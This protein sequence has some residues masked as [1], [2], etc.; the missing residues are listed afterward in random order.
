MLVWDRGS[1]IR[2]PETDLFRIPDPGSKGNGSRIRIRTTASLIGR[3]KVRYRVVHEFCEYS[4]ADQQ[5]FAMP[6][7]NLP[8]P[9]PTVYFDTDPDSDRYQIFPFSS[10]SMGNCRVLFVCTFLI[11]LPVCYNI[12]RL[13]CAVE[14]VNK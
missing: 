8:D 6:I 9:D 14:A 2:D 13:F 10:S 3:D 1:E 7:L 5:R 12:K 4:V 11:Y